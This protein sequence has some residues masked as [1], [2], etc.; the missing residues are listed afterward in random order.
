M[1]FSNNKNGCKNAT[2]KH[3]R[4]WLAKE[5]Y[6]LKFNVIEYLNEVVV[7]LCTVLYFCPR[8]YYVFVWVPG[9]VSFVKLSCVSVSGF[10]CT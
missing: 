7:G 6:L 3:K 5:R 2:E 1:L 9:T 10:D 8:M 4:L